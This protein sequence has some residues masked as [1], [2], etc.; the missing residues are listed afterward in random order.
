MSKLI[1][2]I[3][4]VIGLENKMYRKSN[5][6]HFFNFILI[7]YIFIVNSYKLMLHYTSIIAFYTKK[8]KLYYCTDV[9]Y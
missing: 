2:S 1:R 9:N 7:F 6:N 5:E 8:K 3:K 4:K